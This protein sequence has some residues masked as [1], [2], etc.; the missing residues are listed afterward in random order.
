[1]GRDYPRLWAVGKARRFNPRARMGRDWYVRQIVKLWRGFQ[2]TRPHGARPINASI[3]ETRKLVSIHAP[4]WGATYTEE[5][6]FKF[7]IS[8]Q[9]TR[10]HGARLADIDDSNLSFDVSIHAPAWGATP[11]LGS[12]LSAHRFQSTRP[13]GARLY[14]D[15][16]QVRAHMFQS[17]RPH[18]ARPPQCGAGIAAARVSIHAPAWG[19]TACRPRGA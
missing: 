6:D 10:P 7:Y 1:M 9:S 5:P 13:H 3:A 4:A 15:W 16:S 17:T 2:S 8:F 12:G 11:F 14:K 18:G 19:A